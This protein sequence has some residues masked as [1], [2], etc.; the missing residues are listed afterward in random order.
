MGPFEDSDGKQRWSVE[1]VD[2]D[3]I[4]GN[5]TNGRENRTAPEWIELSLREGWEMDETMSP[6]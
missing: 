4:S 5:D 3:R 6:Q 2:T 1:L